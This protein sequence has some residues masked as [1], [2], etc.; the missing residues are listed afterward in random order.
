MSDTVFNEMIKFIESV[1]IG[2]N[3]YSFVGLS[4]QDRLMILE[5]FKSDA[6]D[7]LIKKIRLEYGIYFLKFLALKPKGDTPIDEDNLIPLNASLYI[8]N[9]K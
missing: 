7:A 9:K 2:G 4:F 1:E 5:K 3:T 6:I 8:V